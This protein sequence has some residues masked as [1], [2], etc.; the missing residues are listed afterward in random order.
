METTMFTLTP[1]SYRMTINGS[2]LE[3]TCVLVSMSANLSAYNGNYCR[4]I[5][6]TLQHRNAHCDS[7][8]I[9]V[10]QHGSRVMWREKGD[11]ET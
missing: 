2:F 4:A 8:V 10:Y 7:N 11:N 1:P 3:K 9:G 5:S 6:N